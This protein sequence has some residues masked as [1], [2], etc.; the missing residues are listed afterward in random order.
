[1]AAPELVGSGV[2][3]G[4]DW[5]LAHGT[6]FYWARFT[7]PPGTNGP[8]TYQLM[9]MTPAGTSMVEAGDMPMG[10]LKFTDAL[11]WLGYQQGGLLQ[12]AIRRLGPAGA[13]TV[14]EGPQGLS[15]YAV[16]RD[17]VYFRDVRPND[18][19]FQ[20]RINRQPLAGGAQEI[21]DEH[22]SATDGYAAD[23]QSL[24]FRTSFPGDLMRI[25]ATREITTLVSGVYSAAQLLRVDDTWLYYVEESRARDF[26][27][28]FVRR[29]PKAGG[30]VET[31]A[32]NDTIGGLEV[33]ATHVYFWSTNGIQ[34]VDKTS[35][36]VACVART[37]PTSG[38]DFTVGDTHV[39]WS[40]GE[41]IWR[42]PKPA[43]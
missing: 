9:A 37:P 10:L 38:A 12:H 15:T 6:D 31:L 32:M 11:Y 5:M 29:I 21:L 19:T 40:D 18:Q 24:F 35:R 7:R 36:H 33:D 25:S 16:S 22:L 39:Y 4:H 23:D 43:R 41:S 17:Y 26:P 27:G 8:L 14:V 13:E 2:G 1:M 30:A 3:S 20:L 42:A 34:R 28:S